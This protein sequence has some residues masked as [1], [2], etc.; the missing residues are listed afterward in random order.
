MGICASELKDLVIKPTLE[1]LGVWSESAESLILATAA[2]E[3]NGGYHLSPDDEH[4][5]IFQITPETHQRVW[6]HYL[7]HDPDL[8]SKVRGFASQ[9]EFLQHPH[10]ELITNLSYATAIAW[11]IYQESNIE[12]PDAA[13][14]EEMANIWQQCFHPNQARSLEQFISNANSYVSVNNIKK[15]D[16]KNPLAA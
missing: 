16:P 4:L 12:L 10:L 11:L 1:S 13:N 7:V 8:A 2:Q 6:D 9:R 3:S 14:L 15:D 5:G